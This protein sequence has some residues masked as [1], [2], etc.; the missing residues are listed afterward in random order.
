MNQLG[1]SVI[2]PTYNA[3]SFLERCIISLT[4]TT[5]MISE[6]IFVD[7]ASTDSTNE[8]IRAFKE[9]DPRVNHIKLNK[10][11]GVA[12][13]RN[14]GLEAVTFSHLMFLDCDDE[15]IANNVKN[16]FDDAIAYDLDVVVT[17]YINVIK[18]NRQHAAEMSESDQRIFFQIL[19]GGDLRITRADI[20]PELLKLTNYPW[21]KIFKK[22]HL[23]ENGIVFPDVRLHEDILH[24]W[25]SLLTAK[26]LG[27][28]SKSIVRYNFSEVMESATTNKKHGRIKCLSTLLD[29]ATLIKDEDYLI[30]DVFLQFSLDIL[31]WASKDSG[32]AEAGELL[33]CI[34]G[35]VSPHTL[36][37]SLKMNMDLTNR[38]WDMVV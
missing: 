36:K 37:K 26:K 12:I 19:R 21:N 35:E 6:I 30:H 3:A 13:A 18:H 2:I 20:H 17:P 4:S 25:K 29:V 1:L 38:V 10:N 23:L 22:E 15:I 31:D 27:V 14:I 9:V 16:A 28:T 34:L 33:R 24:H 7:D 5:D 11:G 32:K 8:L